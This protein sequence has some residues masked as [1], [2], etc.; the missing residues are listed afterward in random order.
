MRLSPPTHG[1]MP[2]TRCILCELLRRHHGLNAAAKA[3]MHAS[4]RVMPPP[5]PPPSMRSLLF[6]EYYEEA[7]M[8]M[9]PCPA[10]VLSR[11]GA[12]PYHIQAM[13]MLAAPVTHAHA[14]YRM[15]ALK[16]CARQFT[17]LYTHRPPMKKQIPLFER[18]TA[19]ISRC[20]FEMRAQFDIL[21]SAISAPP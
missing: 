21:I 4:P 3:F 18:G 10:R 20:H 14:S 5:R 2:A 8:M 12:M 9:P 7:P 13:R 1:S 6:I 19:N 15:Q 11:R 16:Q 17:T